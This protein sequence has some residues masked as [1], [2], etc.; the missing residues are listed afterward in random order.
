MKTKAAVLYKPNT[1]FV[2]EELELGSPREGEILIKVAA[3]GVCHSDWHLMT[4]ATQHAL[5]VVP[6]TKGQA[7]LKP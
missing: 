2:V 5:P 1:P 4:G 7:W 3:A 6:A